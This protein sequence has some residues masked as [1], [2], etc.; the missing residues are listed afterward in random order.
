MRIRYIRNVDKKGICAGC[1]EKALGSTFRTG[2]NTRS[3]IFEKRIFALETLWLI[4]TV[5]LLATLQ[6]SEAFQSLIIG[7]GALR[8]LVKTVKAKIE[9]VF[10]RWV[11]WKTL[12]GAVFAC[13][14]LS[15]AFLALSPHISELRGTA[16]DALVF[17]EISVLCTIDI[18]GSAVWGGFVACQTGATAK[19]AN[20]GRRLVKTASTGF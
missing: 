3:F 8:A 12:W 19:L 16:F 10:R 14:A 11:A 18:A 1:S 2:H 9:L 20:W 4:K 5:A 17:I 13:A 15:I 6:A 7:I